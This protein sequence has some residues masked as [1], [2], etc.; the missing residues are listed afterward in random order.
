[1]K[2]RGSYS[3]VLKLN[4]GRL[5][6]ANWDLSITLHEA[7]AA[8]EVVTLSESQVLRWMDEFN[9]V[10]A[11]GE[12]IAD[13]RR[14]I[15]AIQK[16]DVSVK[17]RN[18]IRRLYAKIDALQY[19]PDYLLLVAEKVADYRRACKGFSVNGIKYARL[20]GTN[21]GVKAKTIVFVSERLVGVLRQR[22]DNGR[23]MTAEH[24]PAKLEA[25]RA[26]ACSA[27]TPVSLPS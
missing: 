15:R 5:K 12:V 17:N 6:H 14:Q 20:V 16:L 1:M 19:K 9:G 22:M 24:V 23:D 11:A 26:L 4:T 13:V 3:I 7:R 21:G 8:G 25:Y 27:T 10:C 2:N 18:E